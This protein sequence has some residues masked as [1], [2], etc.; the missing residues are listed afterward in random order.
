MLAGIIDISPCN[1]FLKS[2]SNPNSTKEQHVC[3]K[4]GQMPEIFPSG[5]S[6]LFFI[7]NSRSAS[8]CNVNHSWLQP[9]DR[10][11]R[12]ANLELPVLMDLKNKNFFFW[13]D[14]INSL[15]RRL[16]PEDCPLSR[17]NRQIKLNKII[18]LRCWY[19]IKIR[20]RG[21]KGNG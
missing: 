18:A 3:Q 13:F 7:E 12:S 4:R 14:G 9:A 10:L 20:S 17:F 2:R 19:Q 8:S 21:K 11:R 16:C 1:F 6:A 15:G 5:D